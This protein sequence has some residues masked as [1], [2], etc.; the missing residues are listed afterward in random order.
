MG[1]GDVV[2]ML[3]GENPDVDIP[4]GYFG[5]NPFV[6]DDHGWTPLLCATT[7]DQSIEGQSQ[8]FLDDHP[9]L[10]IPT[11]GGPTGWSRQ[12]SGSPFLRVDSDLP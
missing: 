8:R 1:D 11:Q 5:T 12:F 7:S 6:K 4:G 2:K 10:D 9:A 3:L